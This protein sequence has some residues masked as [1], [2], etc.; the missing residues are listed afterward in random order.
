MSTLDDAHEPRVRDLIVLLDHK[1]GKAKRWGDGDLV[2]RA[3]KWGALYAAT[4]CRREGQ[5]HQSHLLE[6]HFIAKGLASK[7]IHAST[8]GIELVIV[9][10]EAQELCMQI[11]LRGD[12]CNH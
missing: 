4:L 9:I 10:P 5:S 3:H 6:V 7:Y 8:L 11:P 2:H 1:A 12:C